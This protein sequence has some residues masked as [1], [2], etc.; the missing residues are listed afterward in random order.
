ML[1]TT[2]FINKVGCTYILLKQNNNLKQKN[3][4]DSTPTNKPSVD[5]T[6]PPKNH[7]L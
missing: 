6:G 7:I 3:L 4:T 5:Q 2:C 1:Y